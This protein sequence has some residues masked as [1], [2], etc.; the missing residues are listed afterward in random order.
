MLIFLLPTALKAFNTHSFPYGLSDHHNLVVTVLKNTFGK[1]KSNIRYYR[2]WGKFDNAVFRAELTEALITVETHNCK[3]FE[4]TF[5][6]LL[7]LHAPVK[8]KKLHA[9]HISYLTKI[10]QSNY[11]T[12]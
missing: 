3:C 2:D 6:F 8:S 1:Q 5:L 12:I 10:L 9:N 7:N 4:Q 11:E